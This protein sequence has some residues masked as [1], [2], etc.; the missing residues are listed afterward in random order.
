MT[1]WTPVPVEGHFRRVRWLHSPWVIKDEENDQNG[2]DDHTQFQDIRL[3]HIEYIGNVLSSLV[4]VHDFNGKQHDKD[5]DISNMPTPHERGPP[6]RSCTWP[7][8]PH[9]IAQWPYIQFGLCTQLTGLHIPRCSGCNPLLV[10]HT[11]LSHL[12]TQL[13][14]L[15]TWMHGV[16]IRW[17][18]GKALTASALVSQGGGVRSQNAGVR[19]AYTGIR[20][21]QARVQTL[22]TSD[23]TRC[24]QLFCKH[25]FPAASSSPTA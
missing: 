12:R 25:T 6:P 7:P 9:H 8:F 5:N 15:C 17:T 19:T 21:H 2:V 1:M 11:P 16:C 4:R 22:E 23:Q 18:G 13:L 3:K 24:V 14:C 20:M 10:L